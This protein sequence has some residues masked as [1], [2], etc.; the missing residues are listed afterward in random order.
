MGARPLSPMFI[1]RTRLRIQQ[2]TSVLIAPL[3]TV[4]QAL[5]FP[6]SA[7]KIDQAEDSLLNVQGRPTKAKAALASEWIA[8]S[9]LV[10]G[11]AEAAVGKEIIPLILG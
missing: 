8:V 4:R 10:A 5:I 9:L 6:P 11:L 1:R 3:Y 7:A 2:Q